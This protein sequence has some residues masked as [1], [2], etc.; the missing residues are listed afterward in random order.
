MYHTLREDARRRFTYGFTIENCTMRIWFG[1][2]ADIFVST[3]FDF[4]VVSA[5]GRGIGCL[6]RG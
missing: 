2:R 6:N 1:G 3:P 4:M 5:P